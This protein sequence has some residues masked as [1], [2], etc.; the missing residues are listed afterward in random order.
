MK[1][2]RAGDADEEV[3]AGDETAPKR[4]KPQVLMR[5]GLFLRHFVK[6]GTVLGA[7]IRAKIGRETVRQWRKNDPEFAKRFDDCELDVT[8]TLE[9]RAVSQAMG[10]DTTLLIFLLKARRPKTYRDNIKIE[11]GGGITIKHLLLGLGKPDAEEK[12]EE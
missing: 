9:S 1:N 11:H 6:T 7:C 5:Q 12:K 8:E 2:K 10:G 3:N 4:R